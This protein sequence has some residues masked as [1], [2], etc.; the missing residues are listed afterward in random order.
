MLNILTR[1]GLRRLIKN[2]NRSGN[3]VEDI[4]GCGGTCEVSRDE[5]ARVSPVTVYLPIY[6]YNLKKRSA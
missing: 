2:R 5:R 1:D 4:R 3:V 6:I